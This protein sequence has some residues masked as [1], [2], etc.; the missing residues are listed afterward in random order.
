MRI[1]LVLVLFVSMGCRA[2]IDTRMASW[3]GE[4]RDAVVRSWGPPAQETTLSDGG[5]VMVYLSQRTGA[6][7]PMFGIY[8]MVP[9]RVCQMQFVTDGQ[10]IV[11]SWQYRDC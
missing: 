5:V 11:R 4:H 10:L 2:S 8:A 1:L 9:W 6:I 7:V 3:V